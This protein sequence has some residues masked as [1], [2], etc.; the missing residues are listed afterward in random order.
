VQL[1]LNES[2]IVNDGRT[3]HP[4]MTAAMWKKV[5]E[6]LENPAAVYTDPK[7]P[8]KLTIVAPVRVA[9]YP[10]VIAVEPNV[11]RGKPDHLLVT[12]FAKTTGELPAYGYLASSGRLLY[13][14]TKKAPAVWRL[15]GDTPQPSR[16]AVEA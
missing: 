7:H 6:W 10:I 9:G 12:A 8:G 13:A 11:L 4:E 3:Q 15:I 16:L 2:H 1:V 5:P 14:D